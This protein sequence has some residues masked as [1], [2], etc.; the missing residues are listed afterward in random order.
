[1]LLR[2]SPGR[3]LGRPGQLLRLSQR[4]R[5]HL[6]PW[7]LL[8]PAFAITTAFL[9]VPL[10]LLVNIS[11][12][13]VAL[14]TIGK[15]LAAP[16]TL[17]N[18]GDVTGDP[19]T[20]RSVWVSLQYVLLGTGGAFLLGLGTAILLNERLPGRRLFR[21]LM[22][23]PW[24]IPG[25]TATVGFLWMLTPTFGVVNYILRSLGLISTDV[26]WFGDPATALLAVSVPTI[27]KAYPFFTVML[28]AGLQSIS[29]D[30][31]EAAAVDGAGRPAR[32]RWITWP[33]L[34]S[35]A[36]LALLFNAMYM[37]R[38]FDFIFAS[39]R[40]GPGG[41]TETI[42]IRIYNEAFESFDLGTAA[43]LGTVTFVLVSILVLPLIP[44]IVG[45]R[46]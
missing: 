11:L 4:R 43:A 31:Y 39:T 46:A 35:Y 15:I 27:W 44:R 24:A 32:F 7:L 12:R 5:D 1:M 10:F 14:S 30:L 25:V 45:K 21:T 3:P 9:A 36:V 42:A 17:S 6:F 18:Y 28:L 13:E 22:L 8:L 16:F 37:F 33:G 41:A 2:L 40:G 20:W 26:N 29:G 38:E 34:R 19:A 23:V